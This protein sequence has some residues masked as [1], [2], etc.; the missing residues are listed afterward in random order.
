MHS[1]RATGV[2]LTDED[3]IPK[4]ALR[5]FDVQA[6]VTIQIREAGGSPQEIGERRNL[7]LVLKGRSA[8]ALQ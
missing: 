3:V 5:V 1:L 2:P 6:P 7:K 8:S 4:R